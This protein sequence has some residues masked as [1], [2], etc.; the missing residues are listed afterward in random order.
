MTSYF[1]THRKLLDEALA[2]HAHP[3]VSTP[4]S[5]EIPSGKIYGETAKGRRASP[6]TRPA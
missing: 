1:D 3:R 6:P 5:P 2:A 4:P